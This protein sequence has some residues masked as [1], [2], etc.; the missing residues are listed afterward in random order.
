MIKSALHMEHPLIGDMYFQGCPIK[1]SATPGSVDTPAPMLG[2]HN[3]EIYGLSD[4]ELEE[5]K[6]EGI[7]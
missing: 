2:Q 4:A 7:I 1:L 6:K 3:K 5:L